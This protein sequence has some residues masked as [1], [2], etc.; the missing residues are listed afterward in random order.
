MSP[1]HTALDAVREFWLSCIGSPLSRSRQLAA[2]SKLDA[3]LLKDIGL[4]PDEVRSGV[5]FGAAPARNV[6]GAAA[7][8]GI[9]PRPDVP[10]NAA[11]MIELAHLRVRRA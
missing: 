4:T 5:P 11:A 2:L 10:P 3:H 7:G 9:E 8:I 6:P 1:F